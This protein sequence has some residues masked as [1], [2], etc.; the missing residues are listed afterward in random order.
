ML[1]KTKESIKLFEEAMETNGPHYLLAYN[2]GL[3]HYKL[4]NL[5]DAETIK[6]IE[7]NPNHSSS[8]LMLANIHIKKRI[9]SKPYWRAIIFFF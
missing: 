5:E 9:R 7:N 3:N 2:L 6:A 4:G 1:G 8:H